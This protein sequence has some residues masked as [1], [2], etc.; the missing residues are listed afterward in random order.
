MSNSWPYRLTKKDR[1]MINLYIKNEKN[2]LVKDED[3]DV[4]RVRSDDE[5]MSD[6]IYQV[7][8]NGGYK[9]VDIYG[10][11]QHKD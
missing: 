7:A 8:L 4:I 3:G 9:V 11:K 6:W 5:F 1:A 10:N 2:E